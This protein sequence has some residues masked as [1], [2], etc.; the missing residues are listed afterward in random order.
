MQPI[1][2]PEVNFVFNKPEGFTDEQCSSLPAY[3]QNEP[4]QFPLIV[5]CWKLSSEEL[6]KVQETGVVW[7]TTVGISIPPVAIEVKSPFNP[8]EKL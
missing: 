4:G 3:R 7:L 1:D 6:A 8:S 5:S 2:F